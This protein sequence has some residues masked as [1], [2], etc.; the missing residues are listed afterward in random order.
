MLPIK[1][2]NDLSGPPATD[3]PSRSEQ[4]HRLAEALALGEVRGA[5]GTRGGRQGCPEL[6][7]ANWATESRMRSVSRPGRSR[8]L[9]A[10][11][12]P[13]PSRWLRGVAAQPRTHSPTRLSP[14]ALLPCRSVRGWWWIGA[15]RE[16]DVADAV[17]PG[18]RRGMKQSSKQSKRRTH[19]IVRHAVPPA[20]RGARASWLRDVSASAS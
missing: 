11:V 9:R 19:A 4:Q 2:R 10:C 1:R 7:P 16:R 14:A 17:A 3:L 8:S 15:V 6:A 12:R 20:R 5:S 18:R 13:A